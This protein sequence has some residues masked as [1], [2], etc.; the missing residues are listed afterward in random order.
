MKLKLEESLFSPILE[1]GFDISMPDWVKEYLTSYARL[2]DRQKSTKDKPYYLSPPEHEVAKKQGGQSYYQ[3]RQL[4][5]KDKDVAQALD[6]LG[7]GVGSA[8]F[9]P[10]DQVFKSREEFFDWLLRVNKKFSSDET[11]TV[12]SQTLPDGRE[13]IVFIRS[14]GVELVDSEN[15]NTTRKEI[16]DQNISVEGEVVFKGTYIPPKKEGQKERFRAYP[17]DVLFKVASIIRSVPRRFP[18]WSY[19]EK[20]NSEWTTGNEWDWRNA[21][22]NNGP[23][24]GKGGYK[25][26]FKANPVD[27]YAWARTVFAF[28]DAT[29]LHKLAVEFFSQANKS[30]QDTL[31]GTKYSIETYDQVYIPGVN[32]KE[33]TKRSNLVKGKGTNN[34]FGAG[35]PAHLAANFP[36]YKGQ[37]VKDTSFLHDCVSVLVITEQNKVKKSFRELRNTL[38]TPIRNMMEQAYQAYYTLWDQVSKVPDKKDKNYALIADLNQKASDW[39]NEFKPMVQQII[40]LEDKVKTGGQD[41]IT[42]EDVAF[43]NDAKSDNPG[44]IKDLKN[45]IDELSSRFNSEY[46]YREI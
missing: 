10:G 44:S 2:K 21:F 35:Q 26:T 5:F 25:I 39:F 18:V 24:P 37:G 29:G 42:E 12:P 11:Y 27:A 17:P 45:K 20:D 32:N 33:I 19:Y 41:A 43:L 6:D 34:I 22:I 7:I 4:N 1:E 31:S 3:D 36:L 15:F 23:L 8:E 30:I 16:E 38:F 9:V 13:G 14:K 28:M 40:E 46:N